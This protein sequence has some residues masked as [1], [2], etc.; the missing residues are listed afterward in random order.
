M[1]TLATGLSVCVEKRGIERADGLFTFIA[2]ASEVGYVYEGFSSG[3]WPRLEA[4]LR[5]ALTAQDR[6]SLTA[7]FEEAN[8]QVG[9][10]RPDDTPFTRTF[11]HIA[12]PLVNA[13]APRQI[14]AG[15]SDALFEATVFDPDDDSFIRFVLQGCLRSGSPRLIEWS[16]NQARVEAVATALLAKPDGR[17][18]A[19]IIERL[20]ADAMASPLVRDRIVRARARRGKRRR[21][22]PVPGDPPPVPTPNER[23]GYAT[24]GGL[25][26]GFGRY[27]RGVPLGIRC[28]SVPL[29]AVLREDGRSEDRRTL[30]PGDTEVFDPVQPAELVIGYTDKGGSRRTTSLHF[31][32]AEP[33]VPLISVSAQPLGGTISDLR[34]GRFSLILNIAQAEGDSGIP[35]LRQ[36]TVHDVPI[37]LALTAPGWPTVYATS[38]IPRVPGRLGTSS[39]GFQVLVR[40]LEKMDTGM[41]FPKTAR[42]VLDLGVMK[43]GLDLSEPESTFRWHWMDGGWKA[44]P[45]GP[46]VEETLPKVLAIPAS[47]PFAEGVMP[48]SVGQDE[49][50]LLRIVNGNPESAIV[51]GPRTLNDFAGGTIRP[52]AVH[53]RL[54]RSQHGPGLLSE[55]EAWLT[56][57]CG[58][59]VHALAA[60]EARRAAQVA[61]QAVVAT[62][63]GEDWL[64]EETKHRSGG[65]ASLLSHFAIRFDAVKAIELRDFGSTVEEQDLSELHR[66]LAKAIAERCFELL[67]MP[68]TAHISEETAGLLDE[69]VNWSWISLTDQRTSRGLDPIDP[70]TGNDAATWS[71]L[72]DAALVMF[73][74]RGLSEMILPPRLAE[75]LRDT[76]FATAD[77]T[78]I[79]QR[80]AQ[81]RLDFGRLSGARR[82]LDG[83]DILSALTLWTAPRVFAGLDWRRL[84]IALLE[85]RMT[86]RAVRY[87][88][89]RMRQETGEAT[90]E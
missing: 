68:D 89:L 46:N 39:E 69:A 40:E 84:A 17:L 27:A 43:C 65:F 83:D 23:P 41:G 7:A 21:P 52:P 38:V 72:W 76:S 20:A 30:V 63:C 11:R 85:D 49:T 10:A 25:M 2:L 34:A 55:I 44:V 67:A 64:K 77:P 75:E 53:R 82:R 33:P 50:F 51:D 18:S 19:Q 12:W 6:E 15:L 57:S 9:M 60:I 61:E 24:F 26:L 87:S 47:N 58:R 45:E 3:Y 37:R 73:E 28:D 8:L 32:A 62:L 22:S 14:H 13:L 4:L 59:P 88:S 79:A 70:D 1:R 5:C 71:K 86:A 35:T 56:W 81:H 31:E 42:L 36:L 90:P 54:N 74:R 66:I 16:G 80:L 48:Q 29:S 78:A